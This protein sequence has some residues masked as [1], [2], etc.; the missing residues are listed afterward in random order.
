MIYIIYFLLALCLM[1]VQSMFLPSLSV[2]G[3]RPDLG[4]I[5]VCWVGFWLGEYNGAVL[6]L[7]LGF[8]QDLLSAGPVWVD[9]TTKAGAGLAAGVLGRQVT[10][11]TPVMMSVGMLLISLASGAAFLMS[12]G[13]KNLSELW[14]MCRFVMI[15]EAAVNALLSTGLY[16]LT[17]EYLPGGRSLAERGISF[18]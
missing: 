13:L 8:A 12:M 2:G 9:L 11:A 18:Q 5:A 6:G 14:Q 4:L 10:H 1:P 7:F 15:P 3:I 16:W 17:V